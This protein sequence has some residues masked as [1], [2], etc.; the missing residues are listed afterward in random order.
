MT[1]KTILVVAAHP[2]DE[3]LGCGG[4]ILRHVEQ[5]DSVHLLFMTDGIG[6]RN[7]SQTEIEQ[8][9][10][11]ATVAG[12]IL[13]V[14][15]I[16]QKSFPDNRMDTVALLDIVQAIEGEI[17]RL[18]PSCIY[19]HH[20]GDL[21]IDHQL[22]HKAVI[23]AC[24][25]Q[26][27]FCVKEIYA[28]EVL[29]A[30]DWSSPFKDNFIPTCYVDITHHFQAKIAALTAYKSEMRLEPH[31][32]SNTNCENLAKLRGNTI[33]ASYAEAFSVLRLIK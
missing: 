12:T 18:K 2:D 27:F 32:R 1:S 16:T 9:K 23:T 17:E 26:P 21:N 19:T 6:A 3:V 4:T 13:G 33:G 15:S 7:G 14:K 28:F 8:R 25:P 30:T 24:R 5:G 22:T 20:I 10:A 31:T 29:S 11:M